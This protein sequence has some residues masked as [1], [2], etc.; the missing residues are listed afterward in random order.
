LESRTTS[1]TFWHWPSRV[2]RSSRLN[3]REDSALH[4]TSHVDEI[5]LKQLESQGPGMVLRIARFRFAASSDVHSYLTAGSYGLPK[6]ERSGGGGGA[7]GGGGGG[8]RSRM[9]GIR[10]FNWLHRCQNC[11]LVVLWMI[12]ILYW[13]TLIIVIATAHRRAPMRALVHHHQS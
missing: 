5:L 12:L 3:N 4:S 10:I 2:S 13:T 7:V 11:S 1:T 6:S 8:G 9:R